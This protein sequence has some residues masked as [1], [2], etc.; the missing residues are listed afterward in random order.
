M[1]A[2]RFEA[3]LAKLYVDESARAKFLADPRGESI[4]AGL[5]AQEIE[6]VER[7]DRV[8]LDLFAQSLKKKRRRRFL[9]PFGSN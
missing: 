1:S 3:F 8:G 7:I 9:K 4:K 6:A 2:S 5:T